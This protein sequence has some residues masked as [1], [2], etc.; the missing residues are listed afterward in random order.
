[1]KSERVMVEY[2]QPNTHKNFHVGHTRNVALGIAVSNILE[3]AG[4]PVVRA[5][6]I[7]DIGA[8]VIKCLWALSRFPD[9]FDDVADFG[10]RLGEFYALSDRAENDGFVETKHGRVEISKNIFKTEIEALFARWEARESNLLDLWESTRAASLQSFTRIYRILNA[11][12]DHIFYESEVEA[13]GKTC[14]EELL[15]LG[16]AELGVEGDYK[17]AVFVDFDKH[18]PDID[19]RKM[20]LLRADGTSLYQTKELALARRKF[21]KY[22]IDRS[23]YVVATEQSFYFKQIFAILKLWG[24]PQADNCVHLPYEIVTLPEGKMSSRTGSAILLDDLMSEAK[25]KLRTITDEKGYASDVEDTVRKIAIGAIKFSMLNVDHNKVVVFDWEKAL[26]FNGQAAP[27]ILYMAV[28]ARR[29]LAEAGRDDK[30][31]DVDLPVLYDQD[32]HFTLSEYEER[33]VLEL[34]KFPAIVD[35]AEKD[36]APY[37]VT[38]YAFEISRK[39]GEFYRFCPVLKSDEPI[40]KT[41]LAIV[42]AF[43]CVLELCL[44]LLGIEVPN[45]M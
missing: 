41:R 40:R 12:F 39:F 6:Y 34:G 7:G 16:I 21:Q 8:H 28:R 2:S 1:V 31:A 22:D 18:L 38:R 20:V 36:L 17:G 4:F 10:R 11:R 25:V 30:E 5:N 32:A 29:I 35:S 42:R 45:A 15:D 9:E 23:I 24:L 14:V 26:N 33:L 19:L 43:D 37:H 44:E 27:Y 13:D 3:F